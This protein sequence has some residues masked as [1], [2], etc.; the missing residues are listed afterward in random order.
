MKIGIKISIQEDCSV[1]NRSVSLSITISQAEGGSG[2]D[3]SIDTNGVP[4]SG[5]VGVPFS[6]SLAVSGGTAPYQFSLA[7]GALPDGVSLMSDGTLEGTPMVAGAF[8]FSIEV[9]DSGE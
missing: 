7:G 4:T 8:S 2:A 3:L 6:G 1:K 5:Q 9:K